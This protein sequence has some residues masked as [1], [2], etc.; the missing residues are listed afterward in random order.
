MAWADARP[1]PWNAS[2][3]IQKQPVDGHGDGQASA[4]E[5]KAGAAFKLHMKT[6]HLPAK[7]TRNPPKISQVGHDI[8]TYQGIPLT[9]TT[10]GT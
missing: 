7:V 4:A 1:S 5:V 10:E 3:A 2:R 6:Q 9:I 8:A